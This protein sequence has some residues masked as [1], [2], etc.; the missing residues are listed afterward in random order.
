VFGAQHVALE[1]VSADLLPGVTVLLGPNGAGK[2]TLLRI[3]IGL[4]EA[5]S[6]HVRY[7]GVRIDANNRATFLRRLGYLPQGHRGY[8]FLKV[9]DYL[10]YWSQLRLRLG[11]SS[12]RSPAECLDG[13]GL[14]DKAGATLGE[15]SGGMLRRLGIAQ[16]LLGEPQILVVD[17]P[18]V[19]LDL[20]S[21][22]EVL[23]TLKIV[24]RNRIVLVATHRISDISIL[25]D[26]VLILVEGRIR[27][28]GTPEQMMAG[29][30]GRVFSVLVSD[31]GLSDLET[32]FAVSSRQ[33]T[34]TG[35][36]LRL[37][38]LDDAPAPGTEVSPTPEEAYLLYVSKSSPRSGANAARKGSPAEGFL[39]DV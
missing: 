25:A 31:S 33:T 39:V 11:S 15:L 3:L 27:F 14:A 36:H 4:L 34:G 21:R 32:R 12:G 8:S 24:S 10:E 30:P 35:T 5:S 28:L 16:A 20:A 37:L 18:D 38:V 26:Q 22:K 1:N 29:A 17:E 23:E 19:G 13:V 2:S 9:L 7:L 6:G